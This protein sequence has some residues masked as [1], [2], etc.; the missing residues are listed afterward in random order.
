MKNN[1]RMTIQKFEE[2]T[3]LKI[4]SLYRF[5]TQ[6]LMN[7]IDEKKVLVKSE[8]FDKIPEKKIVDKGGNLEAEFILWD[9]KEVSHVC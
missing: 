5:V 8:L 4:A 3:G 7:Q 6:E 2:L 1:K 9:G